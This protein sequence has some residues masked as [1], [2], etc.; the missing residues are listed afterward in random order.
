MPIPTIHK[1]RTRWSRLGVAVV[2]AYA[3]VVVAGSG[4][5]SGTHELPAEPNESTALGRRLEPIVRGVLDS[6]LVPGAVVYVRTPDTVWRQAF[7]T[8]TVGQDDPITVDDFFRV[9]STTKT[10]V[11]TVALQLVR[12]GKLALD[13]PVSKYR[14]GVPNGAQITITELLN[15]RSGLFSYNE[16]PRLARAMDEDP[17]RAWRPEEL[18]RLGFSSPP[19]FEPDAE[20]R[21]S[22]TNTILLASLLEQITGEDIR[23]LLMDRIFRPLGLAKTSFPAPGDASLPAPSPHGYLYGTNVEALASPRLPD[24]EV[25]AARAGTLLPT[26]VTNLDPSWI[27]AAGAAISTAE[28]LAAYV[29]KL[30][31]GDELLGSPLQR[32]RL[33]SAAPLNRSDPAGIHYG[34]GLESFGP[35]M[36]HDGAIPGFQTFMGYDPVTDITI[37]VLCTLRDGPAGGRPAN[38]IAYGFVRTLIGG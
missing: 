28:D 11:G 2:V 25:L 16:A 18:L 14:P 23:S 29:R 4:T 38:E 21:Y 8:R 33:D 22:N 13:D 30:V 10:M 34:L 15:M 24:D 37:I 17:G 12:E 5:E 36:G 3:A 27:G 1:G 6:M 19:Y 20:F 35:M 26:D 9:G 31:G 7:G 32:Q